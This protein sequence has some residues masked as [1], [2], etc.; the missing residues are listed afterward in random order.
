[1]ESQVAA[2]GAAETEA[3]AGKRPAM[4]SASQGSLVSAPKGAVRW[5]LLRQVR[6]SA[7]LPC[8]WPLPSQVAGSPFV[9]SQARSAPLLLHLRCP[10]VPPKMGETLAG[11][12][13]G[14]ARASSQKLRKSLCSPVWWVGPPVFSVCC[15]SFPP[16]FHPYFIFCF[17]TPSLVTWVHFLVPHLWR[18]VRFTN[19]MGILHAFPGFVYG[20]VKGER[21]T[22]CLLLFPPRETKF[23]VIIGILAAQG[24]ATNPDTSVFQTAPVKAAVFISF[25]SH[26]D[27]S[28]Q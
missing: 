24:L 18:S 23:G 6:A 16:P 22:Y 26:C 13:S 11:L 4:G 14:T 10:A 3:E 2:A 19:G 12:E 28:Q 1:M 20:R 25:L 9:G 8:L 17:L 7:R 21:E 5:Q 27:S 15:S